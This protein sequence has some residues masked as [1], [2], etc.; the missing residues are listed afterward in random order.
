MSIIEP[1]GIREYLHTNVYTY[2]YISILIQQIGSWMLIIGP[3]GI[4]E[5]LH[6]NVYTYI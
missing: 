1:V 4:R 2:I 6:T 5:Y 3:V